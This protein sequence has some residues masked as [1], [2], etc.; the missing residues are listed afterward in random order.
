MV[1][2]ADN[3]EVSVWQAVGIELADTDDGHVVSPDS[4]HDPPGTG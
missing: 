4:L 3:V 2:V 1:P